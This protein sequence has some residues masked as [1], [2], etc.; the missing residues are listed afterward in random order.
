MLPLLGLKTAA[1]TARGCFGT[2]SPSRRPRLAKPLASLRPSGCRL[3]GRAH[4]GSPAPRP[5][6]ARGPSTTISSGPGP[7]L[8]AR[9]RSRRQ[10]RARARGTRV[11]GQW[12]WG[13]R[14]RPSRALG[15]APPRPGAAQLSGTLADRPPPRLRSSPLPSLCCSRPQ[16]LWGG[17][18]VRARPSD[19]ARRGRCPA[20]R[21]S[22][23]DEPSP[24]G[25]VSAPVAR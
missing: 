1:G 24:V 7:E 21:R 23:L 8:R 13:A 22:R 18:V 10:G 6:S 2:C 14:A 3:A 15:A 16:S 11:W 4:W 19:P 9:E 5:W 25:W 20:R 17:A 12:D